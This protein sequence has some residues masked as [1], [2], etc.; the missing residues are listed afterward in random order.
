MI[1]TAVTHQKSLFLT[2]LFFLS[3]SVNAQ[4]S[5]EYFISDTSFFK[6][7]SQAVDSIKSQGVDGMLTFQVMPGIYN[8]RINIEHVLTTNASQQVTF[9]SY[10]G[11]SSQVILTD[12]CHVDS[13]FVLRL[14]EGCNYW[15]FEG[16]TIKSR[17]DLYG[18]CVFLDRYPQHI[19]FSNC[20]FSGIYSPPASNQGHRIL[21]YSNE[22]YIDFLEF[23]NNLFE[24]GSTGLYLHGNN[25]GGGEIQ[26]IEVKD[27]IFR[28]NGY[29][30][31][32][33]YKPFYP[34]ITGNTIQCYDDG[35]Y[36][37]SV[38]QSATITCNKIFAEDAGIMFYTNSFF[39]PRAIIANNFVYMGEYGNEGIHIGG[40]AGQIDVFYNTVVMTDHYFDTYGI[41]SGSNYLTPLYR[42]KNN[43]VVHKNGGSPIYVYRVSAIEEIDYNAYYT[44][45]NFLAYVG[46]YGWLFN[47]EEYTDS[48]GFDE[49]SYMAHPY[50][51]SDTNLHA[52]T[53]W[54]NNRGTPIA[55]IETDIDGEPRDVSTPDIG[56]D[57][58]TP[59]TE[60]MYSGDYTIGAGGYFDDLEQ[61]IDSLK[62]KGVSGNTSLSFL[63]G[64]YLVKQRIP[65]ISGTMDGTI[66]TLKSEDSDLESVTLKHDNVNQDTN[67]ILWI[68]GA[69][70]LTIRD[71]TFEATT[72]TSYGTNIIFSGGS[73]QVELSDNIFRATRNTNN[74]GRLTLL[75]ST[76][77]FYRDFTITHNNFDSCAHGIYFQFTMDAWPKPTGINIDS[78][79]FTNVGYSGIYLQRS[80]SSQVSNNSIYAGSRG[81]Q[82]ISNENS[83]KLTG[84]KITLE[85][86]RGIYVGSTLSTE[87]NM[88]LISNNFISVGGVGEAQG[89]YLV[90][91][92][93]QNI[94][95]NSINITS[96]S[97]SDGRAFYSSSSDHLTLYNNIFK[98]AGSGYSVYTTSTIID[99][100]DYN[101]LYTTGSNL[102]HI[103]G[104][105]YTNLGALQS[106]ESLDLNT[107]STDP[108]FVSASDLHLNDD[109]LAY[110]G[111]PLDEVKTDI[112]G[113]LRDLNTPSIGADEYA[114]FENTLPYVDI[115][116]PDTT[117]P[118]NSGIVEI[119]MLDTIF[120]DDDIGDQLE[121]GVVS[122]NPSIAAAL[123]GNILQIQGDADYSGQATIVASG[124][125]LYAGVARDTFIVT[126]LEEGNNP[127]VA[128]NDTV[129]THTTIMIKPLENDYDLDG[130][131]LSMV[132]VGDP[133][134]GTVFVLGDT[135]F[136]YNPA[137][138]QLPYD[139]IRYAITDGNGGYDTAKV[140]ITIALLQEGFYITHMELDSVS[141]SSVA[142]GDYD[143]DGDL[144]LLMTGW[145]GTGQ[146][147]TSKLYRNDDGTLVD[148]EIPI[149]GVSA[150]SDK[151]CA[152][153]DYNNDGL[154][155]FI[156]TGTLD[157]ETVNYYTM[158]YKQEGGNFVTTGYDLHD[159][160][161]SSVDWGDFDH[162]GDYDLLLNGKGGG[163]N[164]NGV[165]INNIKNSDEFTWNNFGMQGIWNTVALWGDFDGDNDLD[166]LSSGW[167]GSNSHYRN[168]SME[169]N[170]LTSVLNTVDGH[171]ADIGDYDMDGDMDIVMLST[172]SDSAYSCVYRCEEHSSEDIWSYS[173]L[174]YIQDIQSGAV[175]WGDYDNDGDLDLFLSG[176]KVGFETHTVLYENPEGFAFTAVETG[177][178]D[179][180]RS[181]AAWGDYDNDKDLDLVVTGFGDES[182]MSMIVRNDRTAKNTT[183][184]AP[185]GLL[186]DIYQDKANLVWLPGS[187]NETAEPG[188]TYNL[189][190]GTTPGGTDII[191]PLSLANGFR[192][193][194]K[195]GNAGHGL[196][197]MVFGLQ[198]NTT[199]Y[200]SVQTIDN[201]FIGSPFANEKS[202]TT[203]AAVSKK[204]VLN[205][206]VRVYPNPVIDK[207]NIEFDFESTT[208]VMV[209]IYN[210]MGHLISTNNWQIEPGGTT[211]SIILSQKGIYFVLLHYADNNY[212]IKVIN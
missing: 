80:M 186:E 79:S 3:L 44:P 89:I 19:Q 59:M 97:V 101:D 56:A 94:Y 135:A 187:D 143:A 115:P 63:P 206:F 27:N 134:Q 96:T 106:G 68:D 67:Y 92:D 139:T 48:T 154:L 103:N 211:K 118:I 55:A 212:V 13:N 172:N 198:P 109:T 58:Y 83:Y 18:H 11:D 60:A 128:V 5:G 174:A 17:G 148:S 117:I 133:Q 183:P 57:E 82:L 119:A 77:N 180:G 24:Y 164:Y 124:T 195:K 122:D 32:L 4:Y 78:N 145:L 196:D 169:F 36:L 49:H 136:N 178:P 113:D 166:I 193:V 28:E 144:D 170:T 129:V 141:H 25:V 37:S 192:Q 50:F 131:E 72:N 81:I 66:L 185:H 130:D 102:A 203:L 173:L 104:T 197:Y 199:Y 114:P 93:F 208:L 20:V 188:L 6:S 181:A 161:S 73:E 90:T 14:G 110:L 46:D 10:Y 31:M 150:G 39:S 76:Q 190:M 8:E 98:N 157:G 201:S 26:G 62:L 125:D 158:I 29:M 47:L 116:I 207:L 126:I 138:Y 100:S 202:F 123:S 69:D 1:T 95:H 74:L 146:N 153:T 107:V 200:W 137:G 16:I 42:I 156:I 140:F 112:D 127:P 171:S 7:F 34:V 12:S 88:G 168:D 189:R 151:S 163:S 160:T 70:F 15:N 86:G 91:S 175:I 43:V 105:D 61:A 205:S 179:L 52:K 165:Y 64:E 194:P 177:L 191:S 99:S 75:Y 155:D 159:V 85:N 84:N 176:T 184:E 21:V 54:Y 51:V 9:K 40:G 132:W 35:I 162:D 65:Y 182:P 23:E 167:E 121:F 120:K 41:Y 22:A 38:H 149:Q 71:L 87:T 108:V 2:I 30:G 209:R 111:Y 152:W 204:E 53:S 33:M 45:G 142:W 210:E 147:H